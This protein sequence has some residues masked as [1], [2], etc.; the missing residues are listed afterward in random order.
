MSQTIKMDKNYLALI[1]ES[2]DTETS[3]INSPEKDLI[4]LNSP[5]K[6]PWETFSSPEKDPIQPPPPLPKRSFDLSDFLTTSSDNQPPP[7]PNRRT[8]RPKIFVQP[9]LHHDFL[10]TSSERDEDERE[11]PIT[12][13]TPLIGRKNK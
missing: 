5:V 9:D 13:K 10:A 11:S 3:V 1:N 7:L 6:T 8:Y 12:D 4:D 2:T